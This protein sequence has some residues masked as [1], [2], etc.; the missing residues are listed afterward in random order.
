M[1][2]AWISNHR[3]KDEVKHVESKGIKVE[4]SLWV[5]LTTFMHGKKRNWGK[6]VLNLGI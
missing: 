4:I 6:I 1:V 5:S 2:I 3:L